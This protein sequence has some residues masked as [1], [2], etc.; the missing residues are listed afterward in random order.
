LHKTRSKERSPGLPERG[1]QRERRRRKKISWRRSE[2]RRLS[3]LE[4]IMPEKKERGQSL[5][6]NIDKTLQ[7]GQRLREAIKESREEILKLLFDLLPLFGR[8]RRRREPLFERA[9]EELRLSGALKGDLRPGAVR[10][11]DLSSQGR[12]GQELLELRGRELSPA[13]KYGGAKSR[14]SSRG[15][16]GEKSEGAKR[17]RRREALASP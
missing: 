6:C 7:R 14:A 12:R 2:G 15:E 8:E 9:S 5:P 17:R 16:H 3:P 10:G 13:L 1:G 11:S 4:A